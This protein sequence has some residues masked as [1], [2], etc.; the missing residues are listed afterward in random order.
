M[1]TDRIAHAPVDKAKVSSHLTLFGM[2]GGSIGALLAGR[3][4]DWIGLQKVFLAWLL[5][6]LIIW[7]AYH[8]Q[9]WYQRANKRSSITPPNHNL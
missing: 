7:V 5:P 1:N 4:A 6:W 2:L 3:L 8:G 9:R